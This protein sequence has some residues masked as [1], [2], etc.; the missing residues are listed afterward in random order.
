MVND[1][2]RPI[3]HV[4][5]ISEDTYSKKFGGARVTEIDILHYDDPTPPATLTGDL[6]DAPHIPS[7]QFD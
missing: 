6:T 3:G 1:V 5:E 7:N 4:L 2:V